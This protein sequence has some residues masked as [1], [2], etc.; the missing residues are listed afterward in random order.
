[1]SNPSA[2]AIRVAADDLYDRPYRFAQPL[3]YL[4][5]REQ[6]RLL[7][8]RG[9]LHEQPRAELRVSATRARS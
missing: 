5:Q 8:L 1:M 7:I 4:S 9:R 3:N 6:A 2:H